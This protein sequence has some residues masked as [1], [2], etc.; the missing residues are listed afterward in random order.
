[1]SMFL[2]ALANLLEDEGTFGLGGMS[3][4]VWR[5][6]IA[7]YKR[8]QAQLRAEDQRPKVATDAEDQ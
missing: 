6:E 5:E 8:Q 3:E 7:D 1:V 4:A 2:Q